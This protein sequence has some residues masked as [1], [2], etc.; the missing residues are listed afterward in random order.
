MTCYR[1]QPTY[2]ELKLIWAM[3]SL[4]SS[5][6]SAYLWGIETPV[7]GWPGTGGYRFQPTYEE[8]KQKWAN[9]E[10]DDKEMF[11][12]YLWGIETNKKGVLKN[13]K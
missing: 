1:F 12:A 9:R 4:I 11:S 3:Y 5:S 6:F 10:Y 7:R 2:E 13:E 8:L